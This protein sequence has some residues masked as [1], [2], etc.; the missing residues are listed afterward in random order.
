VAQYIADSL[1]D[2]QSHDR[3]FQDGRLRNAYQGGD[4]A[5]PPGWI[6]N[7]KSGTVLM[8]GW[9]DPSTR[10]WYEDETHV[11]TNTGNVGWAMLALLYF[12]EVTHERP[13]L[14]AASRLGDWTIANTWDGQMGNAGWKGERSL[15]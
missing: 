11:S 6:P 9:Y 14:A 1:I 4:L 7:G 3:F 2:A 10:T 13:Y 12:Y 8:P 5:L 15:G